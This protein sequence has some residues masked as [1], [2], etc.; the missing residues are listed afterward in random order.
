M[1]VEN[2]PGETAFSVD[3]E[4]DG[5]NYKLQ[6]KPQNL[7]DQ[8]LYEI[9]DNDLLCVIGLNEEK[10]WEPDRDFPMEFAEKIG[11]AIDKVESV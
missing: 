10:K 11:D 3:V 4:Y 8:V 5:K 1:I 6:V 7:I 2:M 9:Y